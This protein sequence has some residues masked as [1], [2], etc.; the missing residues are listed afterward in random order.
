M[1]APLNDTVMWTNVT[2]FNGGIWCLRTVTFSL[3]LLRSA[4][5]ASTFSCK[6]AQS[7]DQENLSSMPSGCFMSTQPAT[8]CWY[9]VWRKV[10]FS[11]NE[12]RKNWF[13]Y[14]NIARNKTDEGTSKSAWKIELT[15]Y[16]STKKFL[17]SIYGFFIIYIFLEL[18]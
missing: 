13:L 16:W 7:S 5:R 1:S 15:V 14:I 10:S 3:A 11:C 9:R 12:I 18:W 2:G 6:T 17:K 4:I 8:K